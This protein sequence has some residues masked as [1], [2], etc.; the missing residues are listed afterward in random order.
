MQCLEALYGGDCMSEY[1]F[2]QHILREIVPVHAVSVG[3]QHAWRAQ[4]S[5]AMRAQARRARGTGHCTGDAQHVA[6]LELPYS[7]PPIR[8]GSQTD[9]QIRCPYSGASL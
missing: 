4:A 6:C 2:L 8:C 9:S 3:N 5:G 7:G 1:S